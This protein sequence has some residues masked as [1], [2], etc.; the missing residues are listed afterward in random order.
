[1]TDPPLHWRALLRETGGAVLALGTDGHELLAGTASGPFIASV[2]D[3]RW[4][5]LTPPPGQEHLELAQPVTIAPWGDRYLGTPQG[6]LRQ[7]SDGTWEHC[8][9]TGLTVAIRTAVVDHRRLVAVADRFDG[10]L[11]SHDGGREW[12]PANAGLAL[13][14]EVVDL[15]L[16]PH[17]ARDHLA[18]LVTADAV[19]LSRS[20]RFAWHECEAPPGSLE[21][22][23]IIP[24]HH[25]PILFLG[26]ELGLFRSD[27]LGRS[28]IPVSLP[29]TGSCNVLATD[30]K[31]VVIAAAIGRSIVRSS[32][33]GRTW[34]RLPDLPSHVL[35]LAVPT[36]RLVVA[37]TL[38]RGCL[39]WNAETG[40]WHPDDGLYGRLPIGLLVRNQ[41][42]GHALVQVDYSGTV[43]HSVDE[44]GSWSRVEL[45]RGIAQVAGGRTGPVFLLSLDGIVRSTDL[46]SWSTVLP[47]E[48]IAETAWLLAADDGQ[49]V[50]FVFQDMSETLEPIV[51]ISVSDDGGTTWHE[52]QSRSGL[53]LR[54]A[55]LSPD[56]EALALVTIRVERAHPMLSVLL[57]REWTDHRWP[58]PLDESSLVRLAWSPVGDAVLAVTAQEVRL[59]RPVRQ[60][61]MRIGTIGRI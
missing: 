19:Y 24:G 35:S 40:S 7:R 55:A 50:F 32:D 5:P 38:A 16:S 44:G 29:V 26:G 41:S 34:E 57:G 28:W 6:I 25:G 53:A 33:H 9:G 21:C 23:A 15:V 22:G 27:D 37:G 56:G 13:L 4:L 30:P 36:P 18:L 60:R 20:R 46:E 48:D 31:T 17:F 14:S 11:V 2:D 1:M 8:L 58:D 12:Q 51:R 54:G 10:V 39:R 47:V 43:F 49:R 59:V 45:D 42:D 52:L 3:R 61:R